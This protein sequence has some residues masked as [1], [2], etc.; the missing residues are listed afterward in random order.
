MNENWDKTSF[1]TFCKKNLGKNQIMVEGNLVANFEDGEISKLLSSSAIIEITSTECLLGEINYS[2]KAYVNFIFVTTSNKIE[3]KSTIIDFSGKFSDSVITPTC[4]ITTKSTVI[5]NIVTN[6]SNNNVKFNFYVETEFCM[7]DIYEINA[8]NGGDGIISKEEE[9]CINSFFGMVSESSNVEEKIEV[10]EKVENVIFTNIST[11]ILSTNSI[12]NYAS[13][14]YQLK[15]EVFYSYIKDEVM[16][17]KK[18]DKVTTF[19]HDMAF[20]GITDKT[21]LSPK[22][23]L[24][25]EV[26]TNSLENLDNKTSINLTIPLNFT[27]VAS[28]EME[29]K[30]AEDVYSLTNE[31]NLTLSN[32]LNQK[33]CESI[34]ID[35]KISSDV[36]L[37]KEDERIEKIVYNTN[38]NFVLTNYENKGKDIIV[39]GIAYT[40]IVYLS[41]DELEKKSIEV[42]IPFSITENCEENENSTLW[43][44]VNLKNIDVY[45]KKGREFEIEISMEI[46]LKRTLCTSYVYISDVEIAEEIEPCPYALEIYYVKPNENIWDIAKKLKTTSDSILNQN[47]N[48]TLPLKENDKLVIYRQKT[49]NF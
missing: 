27:I 23:N 20:D 28:N 12:N 47:Q 22:L 11:K 40:T 35:K 3:N 15:T 26:I 42:E 46:E 32:F 4:K 5:D 25:A 1:N 36:T 13:I 10:N 43:P 34:Y 39:E 41:G 49:T 14:E 16:L 29:V 31:L 8:L 18:V 21:I 7:Y 33:T 48:L 45:L 37:D 19:K 44:S 6:I 24:K 30:Y 2:G 9:L 38:P 17:Y